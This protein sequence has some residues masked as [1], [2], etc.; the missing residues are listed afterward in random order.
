[1]RS[2]VLNVREQ[3]S[4]LPHQMQPTADQVPRRA[5]RCGVDV[6]LWQ[7]AARKRLAILNESSLSFLALPPWIAFIASAWPNTNAIPS[8]AHTSASQYHVNMHSAATTRSSRY[9]ATTSSKASGSTAHCDAR[10]PG[11]CVED[12][13]VH[14]PHVEI[15]PAIVTMLAV[16]ES[17]L[18]SPPARM[19]AL[20][21][22]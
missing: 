13:H 3:L 21:L 10:A 17:H 16:V 9:G 2:R 18:S 6:G 19:R 1:M 7:E 20:T 4:P 5:H 14:G 8:A 11:P 22:R 15:D 12:A